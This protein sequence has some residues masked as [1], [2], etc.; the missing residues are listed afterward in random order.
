MKS[1][2]VEGA[3][4]PFEVP[5]SWDDFHVAGYFK[6]YRKKYPDKFPKATTEERRQPAEGVKQTTGLE[7]PPG[8]SSIGPRTP[9]FLE[10]SA[11][12]FTEGIPRYSHRTSTDPKFGE[13]QLVTPEAGFTPLEQQAHPVRT[14]IDEFVGGLT[15]PDNLALLAGSAGLGA[16]AK[17][18]KGL[19]RFLPRGMSAAFGAQMLRQAWKNVPEFRAA[20]KKGD[21]SEAKR[22]LTHV[23]LD[24]GFGAAGAIDAIYGGKPAKGKGGAKAE[25]TTKDTLPSRD[26]RETG[27]VPRDEVHSVLEVPSEA[28]ARKPKVLR[29]LSRRVNAFIAKNPS[30]D[31]IRKAQDELSELQSRVPEARQ[32]TKRAL[33]SLRGAGAEPPSGLQ[34]AAEGTEALSEAPPRRAPEGGLDPKET[35]AKA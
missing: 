13:M 14:A 5:E 22:L 2:M 9:G 35:I 19:I 6:E 27:G 11:S 23:V 1:V 16:Y 3:D 17:V 31:A 8:R 20:V 26:V 7:G 4:A 34:G 32:T 18:T 24:A 10:R 25:T 28:E 21:S 30:P 12:M 29:D 15:S 33:R